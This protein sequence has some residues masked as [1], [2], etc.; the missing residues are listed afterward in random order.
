MIGRPRL[1][2][3]TIAAL[4]VVL[5][6]RSVALVRAWRPALHLPSAQLVSP[7]AAAPAPAP[8]CPPPAPVNATLATPPI[9][10]GE[11]R[12]LLDLRARSHQ[13]D[14]READ[15]VTRE[16]LLAASAQR[17]TARLDQLTALQS[18]L[19]ALEQARQQRDDASW[20]GLV[21]LYESMKPRD[22]ATIFND[23]DMAVLL[24]VVDRMKD[25]KAA[26]ILAAMD[27]AKARTLTTDL[28]EARLHANSIAP[29]KGS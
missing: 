22:A 26:A 17:L 4:S 5:G 2:P 10:P 9:G 20:A 28:A 14:K 24:P 27:A 15:V 29:A 21:K 25:A 1:L 3:L 12:L 19:D 8:Q 23:L 7:A 6:T 11:E 18:R 13:L 16:K